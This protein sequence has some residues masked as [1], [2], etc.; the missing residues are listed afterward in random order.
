HQ[1][2][3]DG[4]RRL[5]VAALAPEGDPAQDRDVLVPR[6]GVLAVRA[7]RT[8]D[9]DARR[10]RIVDLRLA[11]DLQAVALPLPFQAPRQA[12]DHHVEEAAEHQ[13]EAG[14]ERIAEGRVLIE[15]CHL[16]GARQIAAASLKIGRYMPTTIAPTMPPMK[17]MISG[18][19]RLDS[20]STALLTSCS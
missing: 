9:H 17:I 19:S 16:V 10:R 6:Q 4:D 11:Q 3:L 13:A 7:V 15:E 5:A 14:G 2:V 20:A 18:S 12:Q 8:L 1:W